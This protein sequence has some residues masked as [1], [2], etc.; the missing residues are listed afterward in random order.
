MDAYSTVPTGITDSKGFLAFE[1][2]VRR[3]Q[4]DLKVPYFAFF[5]AFRFY[6]SCLRVLPDKALCH[7]HNGL[8]CVGAAFACKRLGIP[9]V[10]TFSADPLFE[11]NLVGKPLKGIHYRVASWEAGFT[12]RLAKRII[13]VSTPAKKHLID[14]WGVEADKVVVIPN[15]VD[16]HHFHPDYDPVPIRDSLRLG[17]APVIGFL[18]GFQPWHGIEILVESLVAVGEKFPEAKLLLIGD[19]RARASIE[20]KI[21]SLRLRSKVIITGMVPLSKAPE[22]LS[23]VDIAVLPY[24]A[25][26]KELWFS[27]LKLYEYMAAGKAIVASRSGQIAEVIED[28]R[29]GLLVEP[30]DVQALAAALLR[31]LG[32][33]GERYRLGQNARLQAVEKH[34]WEQYINQ[35]ESVYFDVLDSTGSS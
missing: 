32:H 23:V 27:P 1:S 30:G 4:R 24:P 12:Y 33:P 3:V 18:G 35:V 25:F 31:L 28:G 8:F 22:Y 17:N 15:G 26:E 5:D 29:N 14:A 19:G 2:V 20:E 16:S 7:E 21:D 9:Y 13:C 11:R 34:S 6:E 10:L